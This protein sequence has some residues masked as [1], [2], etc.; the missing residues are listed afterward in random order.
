[1][2]PQTTTQRPIKA[3]LGVAADVA[4]PVLDVLE[5]A[6]AL[7]PIP[8][9][10]LIPRTLSN[11]LKNVERARVNAEAR[12]AFISQVEALGALIAR[13]AYPNEALAHSGTGGSERRMGKAID[14]VVQ[15]DELIKGIQD[16]ER[17]MKV[18]EARASRKR[19]AI[20]VADMQRDLMAA[21]EQFRFRANAAIDRGV[22]E[23][24][25]LLLEAEEDR[26]LEKLC[27]VDV[28]YRSVSEPKSQ[29]MEGT[30]ES[31]LEGL[32][33]WCTD[34]VPDPVAPKRVY[35]VSGGAGVGKSSVAYRHCVQLSEPSSATDA[36]RLGASIFID[37]NRGGL[38]VELLFHALA[39]QLAESLPVLR[40]HILDA[41]REYLKKGQ[42]QLPE[43]SFKELLHEPLSRAAAEIPVGLRLVVV[44]DGLDEC[45]EQPALQDG[46]RRLLELVT[47]FPWLYLFLASRPVPSIMTVLEGSMAAAIVHHYDLQQDLMN[48]ADVKMFLESSVPQIPKYSSF[49]ETHP[50]YL[51]ELVERADGLFIFAR[52][53]LNVLNQ[54]LYRDNPEEGFQV[55]LSKENGLDKMDALYLGILRAAFPPRDLVQ[56][57]RLH[58][59]LLS[60]LHVVALLRS[61]LSPGCVA[62]F[63]DDI[64][65]RSYILGRVGNGAQKQKALT[66]DDFVPII[67]L[68]RSVIYTDPSDGTLMPI[69]M[70]FY[71]FLVD[72]CTDPQYRVDRCA[73]HAA[74]ALSCLSLVFPGGVKDAVCHLPRLADL[75]HD[76]WLQAF[77]YGFYGDG[78]LSEHIGG[79][80][81]HEELKDALH[82]A[83]TTAWFPYWTRIAVWAETP[84]QRALNLR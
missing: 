15:S 33:K 7:V 31:I 62:L 34:H 75:E 4:M 2:D 11:V 81:P 38:T 19:D 22:Q 58:A 66:L 27:S 51:E 60:F 63:A 41:A 25:R 84:G 44:I 12:K 46:I 83:L 48:R 80:I 77:L 26:L 30:R 47:K 24:R 43:F 42:R 21:I 65:G 73:G 35:F 1:M 29:L 37:R 72:R 49:L 8:G 68:L 32:R 69:H 67:N 50:S 40:P 28:G 76:Y 23:V 20:V 9:L 61:P 39:R 82:T 74:L 17:T 45:D 78:S 57:P 79:A 5:P 56:S 3:F 64:H 10:G 70:S 13:I 52:I 16:L 14:R 6:L 71:E 55:V 18:L 59:R 54:D 36:P 53:A